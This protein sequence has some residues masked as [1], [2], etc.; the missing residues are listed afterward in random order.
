MSRRRNQLCGAALALLAAACTSPGMGYRSEVTDPDVRLAALMAAHRGEDAAHCPDGDPDCHAE[1]GE[2]CDPYLRQK[3]DRGRI[4]VDAQSTQ[5]EIERLALEF[6]NHAPTLFAAAVI[7]YDEG[8]WEV[9]SGYLDELLARHPVH[10]EAGVLRSRIAIQEG[11][12]PGAQRQLQQQ[13]QYTPDH[14]GLR[15]ALSATYFLDGDL[16]E[17]LAELEV[18]ERL[19]APAWRVAF[20]R[21]LIAETAGNP[22]AA[23]EQYEIS[24]AGKP[25]Y[26]PAGSRRAGL[27]ATAGEEAF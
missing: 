3:E 27:L 23:I 18:A 10:P 4:V 25:D 20:N 5:I 7:S 24:L 22:R 16:A 21:G 2:E 9:A 11:N 8:E 13:I 17:S 19:G 15:E 26:R 14:A 6:P 12:L 1:C